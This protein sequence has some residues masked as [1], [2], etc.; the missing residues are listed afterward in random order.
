VTAVTS[1]PLPDLGHGLGAP[2]DVQTRAEAARTGGSRARSAF[3][4]LGTPAG[5]GVLAVV[6]AGLAIRIFILTHAIGSLD[7]DEATTG[8]VARHILHQ[9]RYPVF[10]WSSNYGGT[11]EAF[12]TAGAFAVFGSSVFVLKT[13]AVCWYAAACLLTWRLGRRLF[14]SRVGAVA[15]LLLWVWPASFVWWST[16]SRGF[17]GSLLVL[18]LLVALAAL[19]I[20]DRPDTKID[21]LALGLAL[22]LGW[23]VQPQIAVLAIPIGGWLL[24]LRRRAFARAWLAVPTV[25]LGAAPW[26]LWNIRYRFDSFHVPPQPTS[27]PYATRLGGFWTQGLPMATGLRV[28]YALRWIDQFAQNLYPLLA[29]TIA[30]IVIARHR[31]RGALMVATVV[32]YSLLYALNPLTVGSAEGRYVFLLAPIIA[33]ILGA[34][35]TWRWL[36]APALIGAML[37]TASGLSAMHDG[38]SFHQA[39]KVIPIRLAPLIRALDEENVRTAVADYGIAFRVTFE[40]N[41]RIIVAGAPYN[42]YPPFVDA[43]AEG[44]LPAWIFVAESTID[45]QFAR[46]LASRRE[47]YRRRVAGGFSIYLLTHRFLPGQLPTD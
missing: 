5:L 16:K 11:L 28:P 31:A 7:A 30:A 20:V 36:P 43:L 2:D 14:D 26:I 23:W 10:Y 3:T 17:Y 18:G 34:C 4:R 39:D 24:V 42:R 19:R 35:V 15:A 13:V 45:S 1:S 12:V 21:W 22:G 41:E 46:T 9:H 44:S 29:I 32:A 47:P 8:L 33:I 38:N 40:T 6:F 37:L 25:I 27:A